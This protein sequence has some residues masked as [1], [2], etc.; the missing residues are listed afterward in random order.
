M[1]AEILDGSGATLATAEIC[2]ELD[3]VGMVRLC[4]EVDVAPATTYVL[5]IALGEGGDCDG[6]CAYNR[7]MLSIL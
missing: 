7:Y 5:R 6:G 3:G 4:A 2:E 1:T